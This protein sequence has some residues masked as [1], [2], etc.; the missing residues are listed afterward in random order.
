MCVASLLH[1]RF[2][3]ECRYDPG[4][5]AEEGNIESLRKGA[6]YSK[7]SDVSL[8]ELKARL[9]EGG[10]SCRGPLPQEGRP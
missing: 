6:R 9:E 5:F 3:R 2:V 4:E 10:I 8:P 1:Y 7:I